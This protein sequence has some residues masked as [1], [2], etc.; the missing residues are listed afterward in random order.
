MR[1]GI[2]REVKAQER[3]VAATPRCVA[4]YTSDGHDVRVQ[5]GAGEGA[6]FDDDAYLAAG[7]SLC[8]D[9]A[10]AWDAEMII[11]VKE[12]QPQEYDLL[13]DGQLLFTYLH[14][15]AVPALAAR[16]VQSGA[17]AL[18]Y[19]TI[20]LPDHSLPCLAPMSMIAGRLSVQQGAKYLEG[21]FGG[22]GVLLGGVPGVA[23]GRVTV[24]GGGM[25]GSQAARMA[26]GLGADVTLLDLSAARLAELDA[27]FAGRLHTL[28][29]TPD[30]LADCLA[31]ADLVIGAVL[32]PGAA[33]PKLVRRAQLSDMQ[34]GAVI[35]DVAVDQGG[36]VET[37]RPTTHLDPV[38][39]VDG[40]QHY[41]V[42]NMP[43]A[44]ART[45]TLALTSVTLP[46]GRKLASLGLQRAAAED[47]ALA[48][49]VNVRD[50][51]VVHATVAAALAAS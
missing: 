8:D 38:Y 12:P 11:K 35:V 18:A 47:P 24:I 3:R 44:V 30:N 27:E 22:R 42:T 31:R 23:R 29:S 25:V 21:P 17:T 41:C 51:H 32:V 13:R 49:G 15:A 34:P 46:Y 10:A 5:R 20:E 36:C 1:I 19:E 7:A 6:G 48:L 14:L 50:G 28:Y 39:K 33:A 43:S 40:V 37:T 4:A 2:P 9:A 16:L 45:A 26:V